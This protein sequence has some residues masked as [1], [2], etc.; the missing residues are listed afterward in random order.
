MDC[1]SA[2]K[3]RKFCSSANVGGYRNKHRSIQG[4]STTVKLV[5][6]N[7][8]A[9]LRQ[10]AEGYERK[11]DSATPGKAIELGKISKELRYFATSIRLND[12]SDSGEI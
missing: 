10:R 1:K 5:E 9:R 12:W 3:M 4:T 6:D 2:G 7:I 11:A 8:V